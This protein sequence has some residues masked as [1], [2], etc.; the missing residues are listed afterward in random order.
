VCWS[1]NTL[2]TIQAA[3]VICCLFICDFAYM[4]SRNDLFSGTYP[5]IISHP[6]SLYMRIH[7]IR[8]YFWSPYPSHITRSNCMSLFDIILILKLY[9]IFSIV[10]NWTRAIENDAFSLKIFDFVLNF[11]FHR[12]SIFF[13][14]NDLKFRFF[15]QSFFMS[16]RRS[17]W[18][19]WITSNISAKC[20]GTKPAITGFV[21][22]ELTTD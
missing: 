8:I 21:S 18:E 7:Y 13:S 20:L 5:L 10:L 22:Q 3:L 19:R 17:N 4:R 14:S 12:I 15:V 2:N 1:E 16:S 6:W 11:F 9:S